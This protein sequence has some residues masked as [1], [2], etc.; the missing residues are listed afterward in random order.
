MELPPN[1]DRPV[2]P[3][4]FYFFCSALGVRDTSVLSLPGVE[5]ISAP[6]FSCVFVQLELHHLSSNSV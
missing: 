5:G 6:V 2:C 3:L 4:Y 1:L